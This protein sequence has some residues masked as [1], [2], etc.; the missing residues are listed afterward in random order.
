MK[1]LMVPAIA[2]LLLAAPVLADELEDQ[3]RELKAAG[4]EIPQ[5]LLDE[6]FGPPQEDGS[7]CAGGDTYQ[8]AAVIPYSAC[9]VFYDSGSTH[10]AS[11]NYD[12]ESAPDDCPSN[13]TDLCFNSRDLVYTF[14]L[15]HAT[16]VSASTCGETNFDSVSTASWACSTQTT[17]WWP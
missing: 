14:T 10:S 4:A 7:R 13:F 15:P 8:E 2:C 16:T 12:Y 6:L 5:W 17:N 11:N 3:Y 1:L 9:G